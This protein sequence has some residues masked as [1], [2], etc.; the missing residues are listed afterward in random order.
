MSE[1]QSLD[2]FLKLNPGMSEDN[3]VRRISFE[4]VDA[5]KA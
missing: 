2:M 1:A 3:E 4:H 5:P